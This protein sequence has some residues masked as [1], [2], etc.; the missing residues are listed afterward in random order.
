MPPPSGPTFPSALTNSS[1]PIHPAVVYCS[2][3]YLLCPISI[4]HPTGSRP[5]AF[6]I[7]TDPSFYHHEFFHF[8]T[9]HS[10][11]LFR[12]SLS[13]YSLPTS[14]LLFHLF[15]L[16]EVKRHRRPPVPQPQSHRMIT[17]DS[18]IWHIRSSVRYGTVSVFHVHNSNLDPW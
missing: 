4:V 5:H 7:Y 8:H 9:S 12:H 18:S 13:R 14:H 1:I 17:N 15:T 6:A 11:P 3:R 10:S 16:L 2:D